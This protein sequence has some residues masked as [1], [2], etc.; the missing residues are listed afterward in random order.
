[1]KCYWGLVNDFIG[2]FIGLMGFYRVVYS[3]F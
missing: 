3:F 1:M 2:L